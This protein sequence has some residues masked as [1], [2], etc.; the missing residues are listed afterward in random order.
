MS[1]VKK[2]RERTPRKL[3][4]KNQVLMNDKFSSILSP[5]RVY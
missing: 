5:P 1:T 3:K 2:N 4:Y